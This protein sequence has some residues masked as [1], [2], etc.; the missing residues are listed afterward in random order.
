MWWLRERDAVDFD[1][2]S[3][4]PLGNDFEDA[5]WELI[6]KVAAVHPVGGPEE[7]ALEQKTLTFRI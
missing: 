7:V 3:P 5:R 2:E 4:G 6:G 1:V